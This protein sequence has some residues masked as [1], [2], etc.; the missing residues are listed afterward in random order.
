MPKIVKIRLGDQ[1]FDA[2]EMVFEIAKE[3]WND[4]RLYDGGTVRVKTSVQKIFRIV[5]AEGKPQVTAEG[6]PFIFVRHN[7]QVVASE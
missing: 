1:E 4:Y 7:T 5:D 3:E 2:I 6:D